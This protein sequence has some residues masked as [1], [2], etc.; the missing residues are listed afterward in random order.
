[1]VNGPSLEHHSLG[2]FWPSS[3]SKGW[4]K[5]TGKMGWLPLV[6]LQ[7][8]EKAQGCLCRAGACPNVC[9]SFAGTRSQGH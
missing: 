2:S 5:D 8:E 6:G 7:V 1:M 3:S 4:D 9:V